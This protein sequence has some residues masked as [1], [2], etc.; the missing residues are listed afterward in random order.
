VRHSAEREV[1]QASEVAGLLRRPRLQAERLLGS[2][3]AIAAAV[4]ATTTTATAAATT[5]AATTSTATAAT[6]TAAAAAAAAA[7]AAATAAAA[8]TAATTTE[9]ATAAA[10]VGPL[11]RLVDGQ[12]APVEI[13]AMEGLDRLLR[14]P[15]AGNIYKAEAARLPRH[16]VHHHLD[17][18]HLDASLLKG[19]TNAVLRRMEG[20]VAHV[21]SL[22]HLLLTHK[23]DLVFYGPRPGSCFGSL[24]D[25]SDERPSTESAGRHRAGK[26]GFGDEP[27]LE[28]RRT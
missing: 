21:K 26:R 9:A 6:T 1:I 20:Q 11:T 28:A 12:R 7:E 17:V 14:L 13:L 23:H 24:R 3:P 15:I 2:L 19:L 18:R 5:T 16:S 4:A 25:H 22:A 8:T 10:A 27:S